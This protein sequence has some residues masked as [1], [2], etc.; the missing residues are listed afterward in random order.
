MAPSTNTRRV[1]TLVLGAYRYD[2]AQPGWERELTL[3]GVRYKITARR[4]DKPKHWRIVITDSDGDLV[5][6]G[7]VHAHDTSVP[8]TLRAAGL[9]VMCPLCFE[10]VPFWRIVPGLN[11]CTYCEDAVKEERR[12]VS[13][14]A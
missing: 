12:G 8:D 7:E 3:G 14:A 2:P 5:W 11:C 9:V 6:D 4:S 10:D 13:H 1:P